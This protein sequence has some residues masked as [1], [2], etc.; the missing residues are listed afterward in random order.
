MH[1]KKCD[2]A[3]YLDASGKPILG[4]PPVAKGA[5]AAAAKTAR[6]PN[7]PLDP[8][9]IAAGYL[10][11]LPKP[12]WY[13]VLAV[14]VLYV[15]YT[16]YSMFGGPAAPTPQADL[17]TQ[18]AKAAEAFVHKDLDAL[19]KLTPAD[20]Y[21]DVVKLVETF[22]PPLLEGGAKPDD[23][24]VTSGRVVE[25]EEPYVDV[26]LIP[27]APSGGKS[28]TFEL[29][30]CWFKDNDR[31]WLNGTSSYEATKKYADAMAKRE[32]SMKKK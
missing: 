12:F 5:K 25:G 11:K 4:E 27:P 13:T 22:Q 31:Y 29:F 15:G 32:K 9:G 2:A 10:A 26:T 6:S 21:A 20:T 18:I 17:E 19:K 23:I 28:K 3:F 7:E 14:F 16:G 8:I 30:L 24:A 1:C